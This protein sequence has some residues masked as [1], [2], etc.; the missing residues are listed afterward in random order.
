VR[1]TDGA[2]KAMVSGKD[3]ERDQLDL[4]WRG[5]RQVG[6]AF[7]PFTLVAAF[8]HDFPQGKVYTSRS[9]LCGLAGWISASGCVQNAE[10]GSNRGYLDL[11]SATQN[12]VNVVFAQLA[13]DV[14]PEAIVDAHRM[15]SLSGDAVPSML[16]VEVVPPRH[17]L[18][19]GRSRTMGSLRAVGRPPVELTRDPGRARAVPHRRSASR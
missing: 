13:L 11:W 7:K 14:G 10:G 15:R 12:S 19:S 8:E 9:P 16:G 4:V 2:I 18:G 6:S 1:T 5:S 3:Y 17:G